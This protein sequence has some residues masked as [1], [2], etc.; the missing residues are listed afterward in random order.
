MTT[1]TPPVRDMQFLLHDVLRVTDQDFDQLVEELLNN[2]PEN[3]DYRDYVSACNVGT[4]VYDYLKR[5]RER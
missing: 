2:M 1:Y 4:A 3:P 5:T